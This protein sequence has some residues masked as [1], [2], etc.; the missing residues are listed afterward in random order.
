MK[1]HH[2]F[3]EMEYSTDRG[4]IA[5]WAPPLLEGRG[6]G[7][8]SATKMDAGTDVNFGAI[9]RKLLAWLGKQEGCGIADGHRVIGLRK[10][11]PSPRCSEPLP[12]HRY[13]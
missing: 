6:Q 2:F 5:S 13:R 7:P 4:T 12:E 8:I 3:R 1:A 10:T 11:A 9:S